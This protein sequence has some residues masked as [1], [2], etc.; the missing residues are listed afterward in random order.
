MGSC[1]L[2]IVGLGSAGAVMLEAANR[3]SGI[4]VVGVAD[5]RVDVLPVPGG[6]HRYHSL[7][8]LLSE[9]EVGVDAVYIATPTSCHNI[10][11][12]ASLSAGCHVM[13]EKPVTATSADARHLI[14][15]ARKQ[16][17]HVV[18]GHS[19]S[20][21]PYV[22]AAASVTVGGEIG[23]PRVIISARASEW[24]RRPRLEEELQV[25]K[26]GGIVLRQG[27]HQ[28]DVVRF[29]AGG[30]LARV[31]TASTSSDPVRGQ[32]GS[33]LA[34]LRLKSGTIAIVGHD[35]TGALA[36]S[37]P[38]I[39][40]NVAGDEKT[41]KRQRSDALLASIVAGG[42]AGLGGSDL[43]LIV[44]VGTAGYLWADP[45][46][47]QINSGRSG[48]EMRT[49]SDLSDGRTAALDELIA[50]TGGTAPLHDL[51]WGFDNL[52]CCEQINQISQHAGAQPQGVS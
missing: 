37:L 15:K 10:Q 7:D 4:Q 45:S 27:S 19:E 21:E 39:S 18:V 31:V 50:A 9:T 38:L 14:A 6:I 3:H 43:N 17:R 29:I 42:V 8:E 32:L 26:G 46:G 13:V 20:F 1:H 12:L 24:M 11:I 30:G 49:F 44:V 25:A 47:L 28:V 22:R 40:G 23:A 51:A 41:A 34:W 33:Y 16:G 48:P 52:R 5:P 36:G 2:G 35:A